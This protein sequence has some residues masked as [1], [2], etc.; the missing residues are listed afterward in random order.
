MMP[1]Q[2]YDFYVSERNLAIPRYPSK[3]AHFDCDGTVRWTLSA[4]TRR[5]VTIDG[6]RHEY[7]EKVKRGSHPLSAWPDLRP[8]GTATQADIEIKQVDQ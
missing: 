4:P 1:T 3:V 5:Y 6:V 7:S 2:L 8:V